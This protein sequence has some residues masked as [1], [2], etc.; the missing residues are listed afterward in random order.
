MTILLPSPLTPH[1]CDLRAF[2]WFPFFHKRLLKSSFWSRASDEACRISVDFWSIAY[3]QVPAA[4]LPDDDYLLA[5]WA[6]FGRR[7]IDAWLAVKNEVMD[8]WVMC[9]DGRWYHPTLSEVACKAWVERRVH[10]WKREC[11]RI[12]KDNLR[13]KEKGVDPLEL[14]PKP[15]DDPFDGVAQP[16][17]SGGQTED[18]GGQSELSHGHPAES[19]AD[20]A[21]VPKTSDGNM[22]SG[23]GIP[24]EN[25][26]KGKGRETTPSGKRS[27]SLRSDGRPKQVRTRHDYPQDFLDF[28]AAYPTDPNMGKREALDEWLKLSEDERR[29]AI[30]SCPSFVRH[31][32]ADPTYRPIHANRYLAKRRFEGHAEAQTASRQAGASIDFGGGAV[33]P[34]PTVLAAIKRHRTDPTSWPSDRIGPAPGEPGCR[35]P[36]RLLEA[37]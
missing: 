13:R 25:A 18:S 27:S 11:E 24:A 26:L 35:V 17:F 29:Q 28:W 36:E 14:P 8:P 20:P 6:G 22:P 37:A 5:E 30:A 32:K 19:S 1:D 2:D 31:C 4:S 10:L 9:S 16:A 12:R 15:S 33:W 34:E 23:S 3:E 21:V 7:N